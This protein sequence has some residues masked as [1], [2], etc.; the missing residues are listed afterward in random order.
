MAGRPTMIE[1]SSWVKFSPLFLSINKIARPT[2]MQRQIAATKR[3]LL[4][5]GLSFI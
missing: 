5:I 3:I 1:D 4:I 2:I